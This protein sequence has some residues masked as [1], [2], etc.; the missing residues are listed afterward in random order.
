IAFQNI[1]GIRLKKI[2]EGK[3]TVKQIYELS[4][5]GNTFVTY[6]LTPK[7]I[8][9]LIKYAF[10]LHHKNEVEVSGLRITLSVKN[11]KLKSIMLS[12]ENGKPL[13]KKRYSVAINNY[14]ATAWKLSFLKQ[15]KN[16]DIEDAATTIE[17]I[18]Q[19]KTIDYSGVKQIIIKQ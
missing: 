9:Q 13:Q 18:K 19:K 8:K 3:I 15:G 11:K 14:M 5:F 7:Q 17:Y 1:G 4:P 12:D 16:T 10:N 2:P 6:N